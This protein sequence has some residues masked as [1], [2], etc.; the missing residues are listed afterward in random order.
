MIFFFN[1]CVFLDP[2]FY[3]NPT[4]ILTHTVPGRREPS[5]Q[6]ER[7]CWGPRETSSFMD[8]DQNVD[9]P[10]WV[11]HGLAHHHHHHLLH[12]HQHPHPIFGVWIW[13]ALLEPEGLLSRCHI[14]R[15][16]GSEAMGRKLMCF[17][18]VCWRCWFW[19]VRCTRWLFDTSTREQN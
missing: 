12:Y 7:H 16:S 3:M 18:L 19:D 5:E 15:R 1:Q 13:L 2:F 8:V 17:W 10:W 6:R 4:P 11:W 9:L 14:L